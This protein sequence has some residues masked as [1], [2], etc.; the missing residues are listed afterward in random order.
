MILVSE[1]DALNVRQ[2]ASSSSPIVD[3]LPAQAADVTLTGNDTIVG[4]ERWVEIVRSGGG[5]GWVNASYL[6]EKV[7]PAAFCKDNQVTDL[8]A[9]FKQALDQKDGKALASLV[10]PQHGMILRYLRGGAVV[11]YTPD[12]VKWLFSS[13]YIMDWGAH[14]GSGLEVKGS[15]HQEVLPKLLDVIDSGD[16]QTTCN[17]PELGGATY[18][19]QWPYEYGNI[20]FYSL[21]RPGP[22]NQELNWRTWLVGVEY[23][24]GKPTV[25]ALAQL[26]WEP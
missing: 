20:N 12:Q 3:K 6:T 18:T 1:G 7:T 8:L 14:P 25:F 11:N 21:Y 22:A 13:T 16:V 23:V 10:S 4:S 19:Y 5:K 9:H 15:F 17:N 24:D 26:S 2:A